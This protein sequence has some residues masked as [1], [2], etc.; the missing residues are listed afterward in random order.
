M[1]IEQ[2]RAAL[3]AATSPEER[4]RLAGELETAARSA[5]NPHAPSEL[6]Q[7]RGRLVTIQTRRDQLAGEIEQITLGAVT[8]NGDARAYTPEEAENRGRLLAQH[9]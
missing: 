1:T 8:E 9:D 2:I 3:A 6:E 4:S 7:L 5:V